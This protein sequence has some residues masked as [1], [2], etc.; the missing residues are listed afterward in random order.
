MEKMGRRGGGMRVGGKKGRLCLF[1][2][3]P[4]PAATENFPQKAKAWSRFALKWKDEAEH[5][6]LEKEN[7]PNWPGIGGTKS[8][9]FVKPVN[10]AGG[11][12]GM[13]EE[14]GLS[15]QGCS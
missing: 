4:L 11:V 15:L 7:G 10:L 14:T 5:G 9:I 2:T 1:G 3:P 13:C 12:Q 8:R 6:S